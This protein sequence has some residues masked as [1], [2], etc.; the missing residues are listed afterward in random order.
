[1]ESISQLKDII[2]VELFYLNAK[3]AV[4]QVSA[5]QSVSQTESERECTDESPSPF[6][7]IKSISLAL[8][9]KMTAGQCYSPVG[10]GL[11]AHIVLHGSRVCT[12]SV[13][14]RVTER[15]PCVPWNIKHT[16]LG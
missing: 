12:L 3:Y 1:M 8:G 4:Y 10:L 9:Q 2:T 7:H 13:R 11:W 16:L 6:S 15:R 14:R 5:G